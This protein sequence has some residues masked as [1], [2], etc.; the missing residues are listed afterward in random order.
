MGLVHL[1]TYSASLGIWYTVGAPL[2]LSWTEVNFMQQ[3]H[4]LAPRIEHT[5]HSPPIGNCIETQGA[6]WGEVIFALQDLLVEPEK[7]VTHTGKKKAFKELL[8]AD[9]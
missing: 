9:S 2:L 3:G 4:Q 7:Q 1:F 5:Q 6:G 8:C